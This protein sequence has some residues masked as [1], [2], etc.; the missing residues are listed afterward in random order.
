MNIALI[1]WNSFDKVT[2]SRVY[3]V[4]LA[5]SLKEKGDN[6][7]ILASGEILPRY[8]NSG[9]DF[10]IMDK[11]DFSEVEFMK[12]AKFCLKMVDKLK[13]NI[14]HAHYNHAFIVANIIKKMKNIPFFVTFHGC[15]Y[16]WLGI[17]NMKMSCK[18]SLDNANNAFYSSKELVEDFKEKTDIILDDRYV[19]IPNAVMPVI[20][21]KNDICSCKKTILFVG[22]LSEEKG[23][24]FLF[25]AI[26][27]FKWREDIEFHIVGTGHLNEWCKR[28]IMQNNL[29]DI[30]KMIGEVSKEEVE[31]RMYDSYMVVIPSIHESMPTVLLEA[32]IVGKPILSTNAYGVENA[33]TNMREGIVIEKGNINELIL[34]INMLLNNPQLCANLGY[35]AKIKAE[36]EF[37]WSIVTDKIKNYYEIAIK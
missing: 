12:F 5:L 32:M 10:Y 2:G 30:I 37:L 19:Y 14:I 3:M 20:I 11:N 8:K 1:N 16:E 7:C 23:I 22:R 34:G 6:V 31:K 33:I 36:K 29:K 15:E 26:K 27:W 17:K 25:E 35:N 9:V 21:N 4:N 24:S 28:F 18:E 13:I